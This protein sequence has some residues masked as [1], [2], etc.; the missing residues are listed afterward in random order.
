M[1]RSKTLGGGAL[2]G[3]IVLATAGPAMAKTLT[4]KQWRMQANA[5]CAQVANQIAA[6]D[7]D[8]LQDYVQ[9]TPEQTATFVE[10]A[11][12]VFNEG[13]VAIVALNE[14]EALH[15]DVKRLLRTATKE[16]NALR[17][18]PS[19]LIETEGNAIPKTEK[20]AKELGIKCNTG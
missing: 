16:L 5:I 4:E 3:L 18:D 19:I 10:Q 2:V 17:D 11:V 6:L 12:P 14:P 7:A 13:I 20:V 1:N 9:P 8:L 15:T